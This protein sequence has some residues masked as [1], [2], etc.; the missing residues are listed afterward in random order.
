MAHQKRLFRFLTIYDDVLSPPPTGVEYYFGYAYTCND[1]TCQ[2][3]RSRANMWVQS[4]Y[5]LE[6]FAA[7]TIPFWKMRNENWRVPSSSN[8]WILANSADGVIVVYRRNNW[9]EK[10][11][12]MSGLAAGSYAV[13]WYNPRSGGAL[14][15]DSVRSLTGDGGSSS[16]LSWYGAPP[17]DGDKDWAILIRKQ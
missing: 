6:F 14:Q 9:G 17:S 13:H 2:D 8:D 12:D 11:I 1:L 15:Q 5:A 4:R 3:Y 16:S 7:H 10:L